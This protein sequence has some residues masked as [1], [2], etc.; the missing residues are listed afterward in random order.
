ME[1]LDGLKGLLVSFLGPLS[2][3]KIHFFNRSTHVRHH[4]CTHTLAIAQTHSIFRFFS[5]ASLLLLLPQQILCAVVV[6]ATISSHSI[7]SE[8]DT[9]CDEHRRMCALGPA[10]SSLLI[11]TPSHSPSSFERD[12]QQREHLQTFR[13]NWS[14]KSELCHCQVAR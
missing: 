12:S 6:V 11:L 5:L 1:L 14:E 2:Q 4:E 7:Q 9:L 3:N 10:Y 8:W 13:W